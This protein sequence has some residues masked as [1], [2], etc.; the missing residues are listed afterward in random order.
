MFAAP[1]IGRMDKK[2]KSSDRTKDRHK[3]YKTVRVSLEA[4]GRLERI[5][6]ANDRDVTREG[7]R[8]INAHIEAE[9]KRLGIPGNDI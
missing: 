5:A 8:G 4:Y 9:E 2:K 6:Q 7:R 3:K 1:T